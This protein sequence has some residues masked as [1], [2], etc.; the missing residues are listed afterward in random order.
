M[1]KLTKEEKALATIIAKKVVDDL[2]K[3]KD[4]IKETN[5]TLKEIETIFF[6]ITLE[7][8]AICM[9]KSF[10]FTEMIK[11]S[12]TYNELRKV[13]P[14]DILESFLLKDEKMNSKTIKNVLLA[15]TK[16]VEKICEKTKR[17]NDGVIVEKA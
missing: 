16:K 10:S 8:D 3:D 5:Y 13:W 14:K 11:A 15:S 6:D 12:T 4:S 1:S 2:K 17:L 7:Y 9:V